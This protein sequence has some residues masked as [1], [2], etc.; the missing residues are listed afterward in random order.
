MLHNILFQGHKTEL[1][2]LVGRL[3]VAAQHR[4]MNTG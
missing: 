3:R 2:G 4:I 1:P